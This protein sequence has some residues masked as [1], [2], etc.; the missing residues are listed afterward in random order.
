MQQTAPKSCSGTWHRKN[1]TWSFLVWM[2]RCC[3]C[4]F[5]RVPKQCL[6]AHCYEFAIIKLQ[7]GAVRFS[8]LGSAAAPAG[9][10]AGLCSSLVPGWP[11]GA[12]CGVLV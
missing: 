2:L 5:C 10:Q 12:G 3:R 6:A 1:D 8:L 4:H 9:R 11:S 7:T